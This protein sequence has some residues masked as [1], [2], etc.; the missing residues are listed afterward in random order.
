[1]SRKAGELLVKTTLKKILRTQ[2]WRKEGWLQTF[3]Q[4]QTPVKCDVWGQIQEVKIFIRSISPHFSLEFLEY[5]CWLFHSFQTVL[6][7]FH[8]LLIIVITLLLQHPICFWSESNVRKEITQLCVLT[9]LELHTVI[10]WLKITSIPP[11]VQ[12]SNAALQLVPQPSAS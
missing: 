9:F 7:W 6:L 3:I 8:R 12:T 1:M 4:S 10:N 5:L 2:I 11:T